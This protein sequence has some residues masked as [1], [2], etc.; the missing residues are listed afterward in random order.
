MLKFEQN[1]LKF[2]ILESEA[3]V[4][5]KNIVDVKLVISNKN[6]FL[7]QKHFKIKGSKDQP[8]IRDFSKEIGKIIKTGKISGIKFSFK[9]NTDLESIEH[10]RFYF[11]EEDKTRK[12]I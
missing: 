11:A 7:W 10:L 6:E 5:K 1:D 8:Q 12:E 9:L 4:N 3:I 2:Q